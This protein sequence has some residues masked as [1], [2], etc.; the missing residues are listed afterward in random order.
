MKESDI[1]RIINSNFYKAGFSHKIQDPP[2]EVAMRFNKN[3]FDGFSVFDGKHY[4]W[5]TKLSKGYK[6]LPFSN[7]R[8]HQIESLKRIKINGDYKTTRSLIIWCVWEARKAKELY[9]FDINMI[10]YRISKGD[11]SITKKELLKLR[12]DTKYI[13]IIKNEI[14]IENIEKVIIYG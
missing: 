5:E 11:K 6:A 4:F 2:K 13:P 9:F 14:K 10:L 1:N 7:I 12:E 3:P 8:D